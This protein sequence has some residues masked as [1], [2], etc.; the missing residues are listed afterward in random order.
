MTIYASVTD[1]GLRDPEPP[2]ERSEFDDLPAAEDWF[3]RYLNGWL[4][5]PDPAGADAAV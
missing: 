5:S 3:T 4:P 2:S 1:P